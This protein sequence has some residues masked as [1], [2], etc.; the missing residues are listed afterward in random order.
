[1]SL[2][3][4]N[5][6]I[7]SILSSSDIWTYLAMVGTAVLCHGTLAVDQEAVPAALLRQSCLVSLS[8][9]GVQLSLLT[10]DGLH[11]LIGNTHT[12]EK[13]TNWDTVVARQN[14]CRFGCI[15]YDNYCRNR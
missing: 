11:K 7:I 9:E 4:F 5:G 14:I 10:A 2:C 1:M 8:N 3:T 6:R 12:Q 15:E 13:S